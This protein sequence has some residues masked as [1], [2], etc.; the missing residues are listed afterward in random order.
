M[1]HDGRHDHGLMGHTIHGAAVRLL[2][3]VISP[4]HP[5][6]WLDIHPVVDPDGQTAW[7][8]CHGMDRWK[9]PDIEFRDVPLDLLGPAHGILMAITGY[10][11]STSPIAADETIGGYFSGHDQPVVHRAT[12]R[13][14]PDPAPGHENVLRIVD[15]DEP[16]TAR[17]PC[18]LFA[19]HLIGLADTAKDSHAQERLFRRATEIYPGGKGENPEDVSESANN[20][21]NYVAWHGLGIALADLGRAN[22]ATAAFEQAIVRWPFG[23]NDFAQYVRDQ[24]RAGRWPAGPDDPTTRFWSTVDIP[25]VV[26]KYS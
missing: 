4:R 13:R 17:F 11:K 10:M 7:V 18:R 26:A 3:K 14:P 5:R 2:W 25:A 12:V 23:A 6:G 22:E 19:A 16:A 21:N 24:I 8:H 1:A 9:L 20:P 15:L